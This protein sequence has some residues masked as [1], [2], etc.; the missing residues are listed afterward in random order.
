M[1]ETVGTTS[2]ILHPKE[3]KKPAEAV[4]QRAV[5]FKEFFED[6]PPDTYVTITDF[7][8]VGDF[9]L[10][11][12]ELILFC[13]ECKG[14]RIFSCK[15]KLVQHSQWSRTFLEFVCRNCKKRVYRF[16]LS[17]Y[18]PDIPSGMAMKFGQ[19]PTFGPQIPARLLRIVQADRE[20]FLQGRRCE[21]RGLGIGAFAY[22]RRVV[23]N[24]RDRIIE[25]V[26]KA[27]KTVGSTP[28]ID[29]LF[30]NALNQYQFSTSVEMLKDVIPQALLINGENPLILLHNALSKGLHNPEMTDEHCLELAQSIRIVL[31]ELAERIANVTKEDKELLNAIKALKAIPPSTKKTL[32]KSNVSDA[33][34][35]AK[36]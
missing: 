29:E 21:S 22:Y 35:S 5:T 6:I 33:E 28:A 19:V 27:V 7:Q 3:P 14:E 12:P 10:A 4:E 26:A 13:E 24:Q 2:D 11:L 36:T 25:A 15:E 17:Y 34:E 30:H 9:Y 1:S 8:R 31:T 20:L 18:C 23:E 32:A 16:A